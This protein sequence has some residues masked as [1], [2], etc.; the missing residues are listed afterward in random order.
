MGSSYIKKK[1]EGDFRRFLERRSEE[2]R[3][4][5]KKLLEG[6]HNQ[7]GEER[8][9]WRKRK[10]KECKGEEKKVQSMSYFKLLISFH[11]FFYPRPKINSSEAR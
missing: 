5:E 11:L 6:G 4:P 3:R 9:K 1:K 7:G 10:K 8:I 2:G